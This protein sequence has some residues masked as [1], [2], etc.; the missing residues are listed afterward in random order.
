M[1]ESIERDIAQLAASEEDCDGWLLARVKCLICSHEHVSVHAVDAN[2]RTLECPACHHRS[3]EI[4]EYFPPDEKPRMSSMD[5]VRAARQYIGTPFRHQGRL[6]GAGVDCCGLMICAALDCGRDLLRELR[7]AGFTDDQISRYSRD[8][9]FE[10][11]H[12][13]FAAVCDPDP[14]EPIG[15]LLLIKIPNGR[16]PH[17]AIKSELGMI[18]AFDRIARVTEH[19]IDDLWRRVIHSAW[20]LKEID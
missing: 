1:R 5:L 10:Q 16:S 7:N 17:V 15:S 8:L 9:V 14:D 11:L 18:H 2:R 20:R 4:L 19:R 12:S 13:M 3:S 6:K